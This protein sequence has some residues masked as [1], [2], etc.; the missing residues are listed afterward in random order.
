[1]QKRTFFQALAVA[2][3][4]LLGLNSAVGWLGRNAVPRVLVRQISAEHDLTH[5]FLGNSVV[6]AGFDA[7]EFSAAGQANG[8]HLHAC[9]VGLGWSTPAEHVVLWDQVLKAG[10]RPGTV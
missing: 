7:T 8:S 5:V 9:N 2:C 10:H 4:F 3:A 6:Q 1:M